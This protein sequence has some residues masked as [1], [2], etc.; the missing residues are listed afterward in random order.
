MAVNLR[1]GSITRTPIK[2]VH[3]SV[4]GEAVED[5]I[6]LTKITGHISKYPMDILYM[7]PY[8][9]AFNEL[10]MKERRRRTD[11]LALNI[12]FFCIDRALLRRYGVEYLHGNKSLALSVLNFIDGMKERIQKDLR[13]N[14]SIMA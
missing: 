4:G 13:L 11:K 8:K 10:K 12:L 3:I 1:P 7:L 6:D 14:L 2:K 5:M 9:K